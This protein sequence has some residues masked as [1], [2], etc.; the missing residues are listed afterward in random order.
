MSLV[1]LRRWYRANSHRN[2]SDL[3]QVPSKTAGATPQSA[4]AMTGGGGTGTRGTMG[5]TMT[6]INGTTGGAGGRVTLEP[7]ATAVVIAV[8]IAGVWGCTVRGCDPCGVVMGVKAAVITVT[9][10]RC[11]ARGSGSWR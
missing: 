5:G 9:S 11:V 3:D 4:V 10:G 7:L 6:G 8:R 2:A 1:W